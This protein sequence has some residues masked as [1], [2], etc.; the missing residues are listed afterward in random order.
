MHKEPLRL[1][2]PYY[3]DEE[4]DALYETNPREAMRIS[5]MQ[6]QLQRRLE[7]EHADNAD[8]PM[9][10]AGE[11][12]AV[13]EEARAILLRDGGDLELVEVVERTVRVRMKGACAGCPRSALDLKQVVERLV[14]RR[15]PQVQAVQ[16][17]F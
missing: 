4:L 5:R 3:T 9:P 13:L 15:F 17:V 7:S 1:D 10:S 6:A 11:L 16:N 2:A 12:R 8:A 14:C